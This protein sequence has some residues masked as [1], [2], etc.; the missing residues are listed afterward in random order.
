MKKVSSRKVAL[1]VVFL[2]SLVFI[3]PIVDHFLDAKKTPQWALQYA[4]LLNTQGYYKNVYQHSIVGSAEWL[5]ASR[6]LASSN[7]DI[8]YALA[9]YL[10]TRSQNREYLL[11][12]ESANSDGSIKASIELMEYYFLKE[13]YEK[14]IE[15]STHKGLVDNVTAQEILLKI[16]LLTGDIEIF[17]SARYF[18]SKPDVR[19]T[20]ISQLSVFTLAP[21]PLEQ[22]VKCQ[23]SIQPIAST[24]D[25]LITLSE[26][27][28]QVEQGELAGYF[29]FAKPLYQSLESLQCDHLEKSRISCKPRIWQQGN[30]ANFANILVMVPKGGANVNRDIIYIDR[31]DTKNVVEHELLHILGFVDE[32]PLPINH[33]KC[34][35]VQSVPFSHN[36][37]VLDKY[38]SAMNQQLLRER[39]LQQVPWRAHILPTTPI[40]TI[41]SAGWKLG[42]PE[43]FSEKVGLHFANTCNGVR[44]ND[45]GEQVSLQ[46][47]KPLQKTTK[48]EYFELDI[49]T[50][51]SEL[52]ESNTFEFTLPQSKASASSRSLKIN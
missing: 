28:K 32:Y 37:V 45:N 3:N 39:I 36:V 31:E 14:V 48:L 35:Q 40:F 9:M 7:A 11:W 29:C 23:I 47:F 38:V 4:Q 22:I 20:L 30:L 50:L 42:T 43:K 44:Y 26:L 10:K 17:E 2:S 34:M 52:L 33:A 12:L 1:I 49:P 21:E 15:L 51:Y 19:S 6:K 46:A 25:D 18:L 27:A 24:F 41:N 16:G 8:A 13:N 5:N